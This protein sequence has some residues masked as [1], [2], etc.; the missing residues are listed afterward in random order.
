MTK[1]EIDELGDSYRAQEEQRKAI[2]RGP[3]PLPQTAPPPIVPILPAERLD[4]T[5]EQLRRL[6][7]LFR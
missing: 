6:E 7:D 3:A 1:R 2:G 5:D 4:W